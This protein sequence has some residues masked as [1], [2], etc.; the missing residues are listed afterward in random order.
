LFATCLP[1]EV[2][3]TSSYDTLEIILLPRQ[4]PSAFRLK[5]RLG[6]KTHVLSIFILSLCP[7]AFGHPGIGIVMDKQGVIYYTDLSRVW[8][9]EPDGSRRVAVP[10]VH[11]HELYLDEM[12]YLYGEHLWYEGEATNRWGHYVW[13]LSPEGRLDTVIPPSEGFLMHYSFVRDRT[14][15]HYWAERGVTTRIFRRDPRGRL[16]VLASAAF[17]D[18]R[19]MHSTPGGVVYI[20]DLQ[21]LVRID[22]S[23][24]VHT[25]ARNLAGRGLSSVPAGARHNL[26][27]LW[28]DAAENVYVAVYSDRVVKR[29]SPGGEVSVAARS[30]LP[31]SPAGGLVGPDGSIYLLEISLTNA[32][33]VRKAPPVSRVS[34]GRSWGWGL[35]IIPG[36]LLAGRWWRRKFIR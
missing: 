14:G 36:L 6:M 3:K 13:R 30:A 12:G 31:W 19:W 15:N 16:S 23:G 9:L 29:I 24:T 22:P 28:T 8:R 7:A 26:M 34:R 17:R 4:S 11:T 35:I 27:G 10:G 2:K 5:I 18:A 33:R 20:I 1:L 21:D 25:M 32:V